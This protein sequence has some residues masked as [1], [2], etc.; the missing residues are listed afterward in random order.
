[1]ELIGVEEAMVALNQVEERVIGCLIEKS[2][3]TPNQYPLTLNA[4][5]LACNQ[6]SNRYPVVSYEDKVVEDALASLKMKGLVR[7]VHPSHGRVVSRYRHRIDEV[8]NLDKRELSLLACLLLRGD[9]T[10]GELRQRTERMVY[11]P[12]TA[13]V[14]ETLSGMLNS[15]YALVLRLPRLPGQKEERYRH[16]LGSDSK[17]SDAY[18][19]GSM[20]PLESLESQPPRSVGQSGF[21]ANSSSHYMTTAANIPE[22]YDLRELIAQVK[23]LRQ[24]V[25]MLMEALG[26]SRSK[27]LSN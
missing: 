10:V 18:S 11:F 22:V 15:E 19:M 12:S 26:M 20:E 9:Q 2:F 24:D 21:A 17:V 7:F 1:L 13:A 4:L 6:T 3:I 16:G 8:F 25:D 14:E 5:V 27:D 23:G